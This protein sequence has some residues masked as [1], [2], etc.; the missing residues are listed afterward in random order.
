MAFCIT[1]GSI[2]M[3]PWWPL[4]SSIL[5]CGDC[6]RHSYFK[7][8]RISTKLL[9]LIALVKLITWGNQASHIDTQAVIQWWDNLNPVVVT[10]TR[11]SQKSLHT[12]H[13]MILRPYHSHHTLQEQVKSRTYSTVGVWK[14]LRENIDR[15]YRIAMK[16]SSDW[17]NQTNLGH[18]QCPL[19]SLVNHIDY[20][21]RYIGEDRTTRVRYVGSISSRLHS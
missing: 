14:A 15:I 20:R 16:I 6:H 11:R 8:P 4:L 19:F 7:P 9:H 1:M 10:V 17:S 3:A 12:D 21:D 5:S 2:S 13:H 18:S